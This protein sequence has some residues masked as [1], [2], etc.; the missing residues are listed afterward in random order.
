MILPALSS[1]NIRIIITIS[2]FLISIRD[3]E[4]KTGMQVKVTKTIRIITFRIQKLLLLPLQNMEIGRKEVLSWLNNLH[5]SVWWMT[6]RKV[7]FRRVILC[8]TINRGIQT[9]LKDRK[10][11]RDRWFRSKWR[12]RRVYQ[13]RIR[14]R[15]NISLKLRLRRW[16]LINLSVRR[17]WIWNQLKRNHWFHRT[18]NILLKR[19][20]QNLIFQLK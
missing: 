18:K 15:F 1:F 7:M 20:H 17:S 12:K 9:W 16:H 10:S 11:S 3:L 6:I 4:T 2:I 13:I 8:W 5:L 14:I 19:Q